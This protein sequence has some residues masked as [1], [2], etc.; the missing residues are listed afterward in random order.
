MIFRKVLNLLTGFLFLTSGLH[1]QE[2]E[3]LWTRV[4]GIRSE[5]LP[6]G[7]IR[8][9]GG[10][11]ALTGYS[12][13]RYSHDSSDRSICVMGVGDDL[14]LSWMKDFRIGG[15]SARGTE[16]RIM[17]GQD[18]EIFIVANAIER[19]QAR[20]TWVLK[21]DVN[22]DSLGA[23]CF[24]PDSTWLIDAIML[25]DGNIAAWIGTWMIKVEPDG[26]T[27]QAV[28]LDPLV[29]D[30]GG[31]ILEAGDGGIYL[32]YYSWASDPQGDLRSEVVMVNSDGDI[33]DW[34]L[35]NNLAPS[36]AVTLED[37]G[38]V[39][40][41]EGRVVKLDRRLNTQ[42]SIQYEGSYPLLLALPG[43]DFILA[44]AARN[45]GLIL[46]AF[47]PQGEVTWSRIYEDRFMRPKSLALNDG[48][49]IMLTGHLVNQFDFIMTIIEMNGEIVA[50]QEYGIPGFDN[51]IAAAIAIT[52]DEEYLVAARTKR[53]ETANG[54]FMLMKLSTS[55]DSLATRF[56]GTEGQDMVGLNIGIG[57]GCLLGGYS[58]FPDGNFQDSV[59]VR[60]N[61]VRVNGDLDTL[62]T[63]LYGE[64][65]VSFPY[66][67]C[68]KGD[69]GFFIGGYTAQFD[70]AGADYNGLILE[71]SVDG[72]VEAEYF[73]PHSF[74]RRVRRIDDD[75]YGV[76]IT[77]YIE[78]PYLYEP[79][80][81][82]MDDEG[83]ILLES[84][85]TLDVE[86]PGITDI[87]YDAEAGYFAAG[88]S[89]RVPALYL[90]D[91]DGHLLHSAIYSSHTYRYFVAM[92]HYRED[93][94]LVVDNYGSLYYA[95]EA[96]A[97]VMFYDYRE[98]NN[99]VLVTGNFADVA[100]FPAEPPYSTLV[101]IG[102]LDDE[103]VV[104]SK[105]EMFHLAVPGMGK[106]SLPNRLAIDSVYPNPFNS[107]ARF[108]Y[109]LSTQGEIEFT[110]FDIN[111]KAVFEYSA[112]FQD[113]G[114]HAFSVDAGSWTSGLYFAELRAGGES[115]TTKLV[116]MK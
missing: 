91:E 36:S 81:F 62:W 15:M 25:E 13:H 44:T 20:G 102:T 70:D 95:S 107:S 21:L 41:G 40:A 2:P 29:N 93:I 57:D 59:Q 1:A 7:G 61:L 113:A 97:Q 79:G 92:H 80:F 5:E 88:W 28:N 11:Y 26:D 22:G 111:G 85:D 49:S 19:Y 12:N 8:L 106:I 99:W 46:S 84:R 38:L 52:P 78:E 43:G 10:Q 100:F 39:I 14:N 69:G 47:N 112:G 108:E 27:L 98:H 105:A 74:I 96:G 103:D 68:A 35:L 37:G 16:Q 24:G 55:G 56:Y 31:K 30:M 33:T 76:V 90:F 86:R 73:Y 66:S 17:E 45:S 116:V 6:A 42:W 82:V 89:D 65:D 18:G 32:V 110:V 94:N 54:D 109:S 3:L 64:D 4:Y 104:I 101:Y 87:F 71:V 48:E 53:S 50:W 63:L 114:R 77:D 58:V 72:Q 115:V 75:V 83:D 67:L 9:S 60:I 23:F 34:T 51:E